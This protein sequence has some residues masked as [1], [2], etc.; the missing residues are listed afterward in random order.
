[1]RDLRMWWFHTSI[2]ARNGF[3]IQLLLTSTLGIV[4]LQALAA[5]APG[6]EHTNLGW[7]RAGIV[8]MWTV[9]TVAAGMIGYQ[10]FQ[11]TLVHLMR[12]A[13]TT[14][15]T[16]LPVLGAASVFGLAALPVAWL[17]AWAL[18]MP[19]TLGV[20]GA[21]VPAGAAGHAA[22]AGLEAAA[23]LNVAASFDV[24]GGLA[25]TGDT[26]GTSNVLATVGQ[27]A[28]AGIVLWLA[29]LAVSA[30]VGTVFVLTPHAMTYEG[31]LAVPLVLVSGVFGQ[32]QGLPLWLL[33]LG[34]ILPTR[35]AVD[36]VLGVAQGQNLGG[37]QVATSLLVAGAWIA[38]ACWLV[39]VM[40][41]R[42]TAAGSLELI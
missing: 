22:T 35:P 20:A 41:R 28:L 3:F 16:L 10:R 19:V 11:G 4:G 12:T 15:R 38:V 29:C 27:L 25:G 14:P 5:L 8:G 13:L 17:A 7:L 30:V 40:A 34:D 33:R 9:C 37:S 24:A 32:P 23:N 6:V 1:M 2:F 31:L 39:H 36:A 18:R 26:A 42:A 21:G